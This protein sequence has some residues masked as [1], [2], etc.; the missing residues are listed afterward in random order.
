MIKELYELLSIARHNASIVSKYSSKDAFGEKSEFVRPVSRLEIRVPWQ[1]EN[2][3]NHKTFSFI[4]SMSIILNTS[5][6]RDRVLDI[7][8]NASN[9]DG[10]VFVGQ[11]RREIMTVSI[12][13][14][15]GDMIARKDCIDKIRAA[16]IQGNMHCSSVDADRTEL[17]AIF[18][19]VAEYTKWDAMEF[20]DSS[21]QSILLRIDEPP[22]Q[23]IGFR[24]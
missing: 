19:S 13:D 3:I 18:H 17:F 4:H 6:M 1:L 22:Q 7:S 14:K 11:D 20:T 10:W 24:R 2:S 8:R 23:N 15:T 5:Y 9:F 21:G 12:F 16:M